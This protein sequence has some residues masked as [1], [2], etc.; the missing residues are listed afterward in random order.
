MT[1]LVEAQ[2]VALEGRLEATDLRIMPGELVA[3]V[4]PNGGGKTSLLRALAGIER[5]SGTVA[6]AGER[7]E[8]VQTARRPAL[9]GFL[10]ASRDTVWPIR[11]SDV[12]QLGATGCDPQRLQEL[13]AMLGLEQLASRRV[14]RLSTGERARVLLARALYSRPRLLLLDEPLSNLDPYWALT[15]VDILRA[16]VEREECAAL[17]ALHDLD[18]GNR[19]DR[20]LLVDHGKI[21]ADG[22]PAQLLSSDVLG[23]AFGIERS[24]GSWRVRRSEDQRSSP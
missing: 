19:F 1:P 4:G 22:P 15:I 13:I 14:D 24:G 11:A 12:I 9:L 6:V 10:P 5:G 2:G 21:V 23:A 8:Q 16:A 18:A 17:V 7:L 3:V 20:M